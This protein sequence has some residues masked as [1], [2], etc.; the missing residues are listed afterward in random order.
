M[1]LDNEVSSKN[2]QITKRYKKYDLLEESSYNILENR[3]KSFGW[4]D[5]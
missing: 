3:L 5:G 2:T 4:G 1:L